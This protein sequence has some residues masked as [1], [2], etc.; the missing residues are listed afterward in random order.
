MLH[1]TQG[2]TLNTSKYSDKYSITHIF[3]RDFGRVSYLLPR[4]QSKKQKIKS[5]LFSPLSILNLEVEHLPLRDIQRIK[6]VERAFP[7]Y[8]ISMNMTKVSL[9]FFLSEFL[10]LV[11]RETERNEILYDYLRNSIETLE[12]ADKGLGNFHLTF[13]IGLTRFLGIYPN[14][15]SYTNRSYF[16]LLN[17]E[18]VLQAPLHTH[19]LSKEQSRYLCYF[20][21]IHFGNMHLFC[22][23]HAD[24]NAVV[25]ALLTYYRLHVWDFPA[26][27]S[28]EVLRE[29]MRDV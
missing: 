1:K 21:R 4:S 26:L 5:S 18:F 15:D 7:L 28:L 2:I 6:E 17:G 13:M 19:F 20:R 8:D 27:K 22:L 12:A 16:D 9:S 11:L 25:A 10:S 14:M 3:T 24:R 23:S 29:V